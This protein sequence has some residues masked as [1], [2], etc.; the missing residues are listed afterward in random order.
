MGSVTT[1]S[2]PLGRV[3]WGGLDGVG[4]SAGR[5]GAGAGVQLLGHG[6]VLQ[7]LTKRFLDAALEAEIPG[8]WTA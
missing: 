5:P 7:K 8:S 3:A 1:E 4:G 6:G 2:R